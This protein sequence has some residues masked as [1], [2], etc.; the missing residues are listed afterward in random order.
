MVN[1]Y[2]TSAQIAAAMAMNDNGDFVVSWYSFIQDGSSEGVYAQRFNATG[3]KQGGEFLVNTFTTGQQYNPSIG[4]DNSTGDFVIAWDSNDG[5]NG[6][7]FAQ[8]YN[9]SGV[10][11]D[12]EFR[13][14]TYTINQQ[15]TSRVQMT[16]SGNFII[17]W[18]STGQDG[19]S[20]GAYAQRY[21]NTGTNALPDISTQTFS[22]L[23]NSALATAV[24]TVIA[25]DPNPGQSIT[26]SITAGNEDGKFS[27]NSA[28]GSITVAGTLD[29]EATPSYVLTVQATDNGTSSQNASAAITINITD[30][31]NENTPV[32]APQT[33]SVEENVTIGTSVGTV[34]A[35][36]ADAGQTLTYSITAGN[37]AGKF[38]INSSTGEITVAAN[39]DYET[40][41][42]Y[43]LTIKIADN[44]TPSKNASATVSITITNLT[45]ENSPVISPQTFSISENAS[46]NDFIGYISAYDNDA[47]QSLNYSITAGNTDGKFSITSSNGTFYLSGLVDYETTPS[48][49]LTITVADN[50]SPVRSASATITVNVTDAVETGLLSGSGNSELTLYPN[51][52]KEVVHI[53]LEGTVEIKIQDLSGHTVKEIKTSTALFSIEGMKTGVYSV[54]LSQ[55]GNKIYKKLVIE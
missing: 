19:D 14:N 2:T 12:G 39:L 4:M 16:G 26:Y 51:P 5:N 37:T 10:A 9:A 34:I 42:S 35:T 43:S 46:I 53:D 24:G 47:G 13:V 22:T 18:T 17:L 55:N 41:T 38:T 30:I 25:S 32:I 48:Y 45:N 23:E 50:G 21:A 1:T 40:A 31:N 15:N 33:F 7:V 44:G 6:G 20:W 28:T 3:A 36:D 27:I 49:A 52:A 8:R 29:Y 54:E 11:Q